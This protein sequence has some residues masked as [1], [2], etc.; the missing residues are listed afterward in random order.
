MQDKN[1]KHVLNE[2]GGLGFIVSLGSI[3]F[4]T[5]FIIPFL[6]KMWFNFLMTRTKNSK[7]NEELT[8]EVQA[9]S[10]LPVNV[11]IINDFK[12]YDA[13]HAG[14]KS[15]YI[16]AAL[17]KDLTKRETIAVLLH[18]T[19]HYLNS[20]SNKTTYLYLPIHKIVF[21]MILSTALV[22]IPLTVILFFV[23]EP[24]FLKLLNKKNQRAEFLADSYASELG[25][26]K[27]LMSALDKFFNKLKAEVCKESKDKKM[28]E[29]KLFD[30]HKNNKDYQSHPDFFERKININSTE[31]KYTKLALK[32][33]K[34]KHIRK[35]YFELKK[36]FK[37]IKQEIKIEEEKINQKNLDYKQKKGL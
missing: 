4:L 21:Y 3:W 31:L 32:H 5:S 11:Y 12:N 24:F 30:D 35:S 8:R 18:E 16:S 23:S 29:I 10:N 25:Y 34:F 9:L 6:N 37:K 1:S 36:L 13:F 26:G 17:V 19:G 22:F 7:F 14:T 33:G 15:I 28:C 20:D 27:D 2:L